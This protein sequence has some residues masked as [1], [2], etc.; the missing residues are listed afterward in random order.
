MSFITSMLGHLNYGTIF[1]LML[2]ESTV[3]PVPSELVVAPAAYHAAAGNLDIWL[4]ILFA[5]LGADVGA[6]INYLAGW[7]LG[8]PIIYKFANS[9]WGHLCL[10]NQEKVEKSER[11]FDEHG[12]VATI[13]GR[14]LPGIRHLISIP[15]GLAKMSYWKFLL[16]TTI[17]AASWHTILALLGHYLHSFVPEEQLQE[18]IL[19]YGEYIKFGL[20]VLVILA[21]IYVLVKWYIKKKKKDNNQSQKV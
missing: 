20:I 8:R 11:Y 6:T 19:E 16:Y 18:K 9:K 14:L 10:L 5:T 1:I 15:A 3:I 12:M 17:G 7:Y 21:C 13:T 4:V 2:L